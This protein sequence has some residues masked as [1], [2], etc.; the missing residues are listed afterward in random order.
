MKVEPVKFERLMRLLM[1]PSAGKPFIDP[2]EVNFTSGGLKVG[3]TDEGQVIGVV[4]NFKPEYFKE[5]EEIG[6]VKLTSTMRGAVSKKFKVDEVIDVKFGDSIEFKGKIE[7]YKEK[8][9]EV[10]CNLIE[11]EKLK[12]SGSILIPRK[13]TP[14]RYYELDVS[15]LK[16]LEDEK[17]ILNYGDKLEA[18]IKT[19]ISTYRKSLSFTRTGP[20]D[21]KGSIIVDLDYLNRV[22]ANLEGSITLVFTVEGGPLV[23]AQGAKEYNLTYFIMPRIEV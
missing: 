6:T 3:V 5:Y 11:L 23:I 12:G 21:A 1:L 22:I 17:V 20:T 15:T 13:A 8:P 19:E 18:V 16:D 7:E 9:T 2:V 14:L 4:A 10:P